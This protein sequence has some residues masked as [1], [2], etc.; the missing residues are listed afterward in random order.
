M[1]PKPPPL[2]MSDLILSA[3]DLK[4]DIE[5]LERRLSRAKKRLRGETELAAYY[6]KKNKK[7]RAAQAQFRCQW[8]RTKHNADNLAA[9][10]VATLKPA[11]PIC[12]EAMTPTW[13]AGLV[14]FPCRHM[15]CKSCWWSMVEHRIEERCPVC[16]Q[17]TEM[18]VH[19]R[20]CDCMAYDELYP[21]SS[22][23]DSESD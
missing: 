9:S 5:H 10:L 11:C 22:D 13:P 8:I 6:A 2:T 3:D 21:S 17:P 12:F 4:E 14:A 20:T 16:R 18:P 7:A 23:S 1:V 19:S 15:V